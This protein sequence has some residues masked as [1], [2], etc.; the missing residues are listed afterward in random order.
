MT[1]ESACQ[2]SMDRQALS[3]ALKTVIGIIEPSQVNPI[4]GFIKLTLADG[5]ATLTTTDNELQISTNVSAFDSNN[6]KIDVAIPGKKFY[7]ICRQL[8]SDEPISLSFKHPWVTISQ[9]KVS[10]QLQTLDTQEFPD[11]LPMDDATL[12]LEL[13]ESQLKN[14]IHKNNVKI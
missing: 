13:E 2:I 6:S 11:I 3:M 12:K 14:M 7:E 10:F 4:L 5:K 9:N 1:T 8:P